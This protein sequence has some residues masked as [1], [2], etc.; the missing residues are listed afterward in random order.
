MVF[1]KGMTKLITIAT[2]EIRQLAD[3]FIQ[4]QTAYAKAMGFEY[5]V[6]GHKAWEHLHA[7]FSKVFEIDRA[8]KAGNE[9]VIW[10]DCDIAFMRKADLTKILKPDQFMTGYKQLNWKTWDYICDG[11]LVF[12]N[13]PES[14]KYIEQWTDRCLNGCP[15]TVK[16]KRTMILDHPW[17]QWHSDGLNRE[18]GFK[19][20]HP[21][22]AAEIG[23][24]CKEI[25]H[26]GNIWKK[27]MP[28]IHFGGPATWERRV[29]VFNDHYSK[30]VC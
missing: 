18:W 20:I 6:V 2:P 16:G 29:Q 12:R 21:A 23:C 17:E 5:E 19:G 9:F 30:L 22:T 24:F 11:L 15:L 28:T 7:S 4:N 3:P 8:L 1:T 26:D 10:A 13:S 27:P 14:E 25:W